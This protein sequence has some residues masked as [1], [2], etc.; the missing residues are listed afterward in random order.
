MRPFSL[1]VFL[2]LVSGAAFGQTANATITGTVA[3]QTGAVI[4]NAPIEARHVDTG[5]LFLAA[6]TETGNYTIGQLPIGRYEVTVSAPGFKTFNRQGLNLAAAQVLRLDIPMEVG[7]TQESVTITADATLLKTESSAV[8]HNVTVS[9]MQ[10]LPLMPVN[11]GTGATSSS[12]FRDPFAIALLIPGVQYAASTDMI[13]NGTP[14]GTVQYRV[15]GQTAGNLGGLRQFTHQTQPSVDAIEEVAIQTSNYSA[16]FGTVGGAI[17]N[18]TM[19]SGTNQFHGS[20]YDYA[21]NEIMNAAHPYTH[22]KNRERR[23]DYG[24]TIGGPVRIPKVYDGGNKTFFFWGFEQFRNN[25]LVVTTQATVPIEPY[26]RGDFGQVIIGSGLNGVPRNILVGTGASQRDYV[27]PLGRTIQSGTIFDPRST[28]TVIC[29]AAITADCP[30]GNS[31]QVRNP[32]PGNIIPATLFDPVALKVQNLVPLPVGPNHE[33]GQLGNNFQNPW[34]SKRRSEIPSI[35]IDHNLTQRARLS[36]YWSTTGTQ[37]QYAFPNGNAEGLPDPISAA[38][39]TFFKGKTIRLNYDHTLSPTVLLHIGLGWSQMNT[40]DRAPVIDYNPEKELG[41]RGARLNRNFPN[42]T[43]GASTATGG[44]STIG[45][46]GGIQGQGGERRPSAVV[47]LSLV[48]RNH[49]IKFG[50]EWRLERYPTR[51][52]TA[53]AGQYGFTGSGWTTQSSLQGIATSQGS[54]G[55]GYANF[56]LGNVRS[57]TLAV[58]I[59]YGTSKSQ[60]A[61]FVQ[62]NWKIRRNLTLDYGLR[63]DYGT[64]TREDHGRNGNLDLTVPNSSAGGH[65]GGLIFEAQCKCL[66]ADNYPYSIGPRAGLAYTLNNKTVLRGGFGIVYNSTSTFGGS[67]TNDVNGG[68]PGFGEGLFRL[69]DGIPASVNPQWPVFDPAIGH[70]PNS[71]IAAP[72]MLDPNGGRP[73]RQYQWSFSLQREIDRNLVVE[74]AYVANRGVWWSAGGLTSNNDISEALLARYG[75][76]VGNT[77]DRSLLIAQWQNLTTAQRS[78]LASRGVFVPYNGFPLNQNVRQ[79][80][81]PFSQFNTSINPSS[82]PLGKTWY[83]ALQVTVTKRYSHGLT[84]NANYTF[85]KTLDLM[86]SP[87]VFNR[88][89]GKD[90]AGSD[91]PHQF[92]LS[93][94]YIVPR[95]P[96]SVPV[97]GNKIVALLLSDWGIGWY[98]Q[99]QSAGALGRPANGATQPISDWL[100]RGPGGAQLRI[101]EDGKPMNP[102][103]VNWV[104]NKGRQRTDPID[105]NCRCYDPAKTIVL[106]PAAWESVPNATWAAQQ[107]TIRYF[108]GTRIPQENANFSR[109][110]RFGEGGKVTLQVR[111]EFN[112]VFNRLRLPNPTSGGNFNANPTLVNGVYTAG[113][114]TYGNITGGIGVGAQRSG[115]LIGRL[116]F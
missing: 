100:G 12:G 28:Q 71:V 16:E 21:V 113:F 24:F 34:R 97:L 57:I 39:G 48:R 52:F 56:L 51:T 96:E 87:D 69:Q 60:W 27:D 70:T 79:S 83:D 47:N 15:D 7:S 77:A 63:W 43:A 20:V 102:W 72:A 89:L 50:G 2:L 106:N 109:N 85:S 94:D 44:L 93:A 8:V 42:F 33:R 74:A 95:I 73:A 31:V 86:S 58:P 84:L 25:T 46:A 99:Y 11:G 76:Q 36:F 103:S 82:A 64:Y 49:N 66:F 101:G 19:K 98:M 13:V 55:F 61:L 62:D 116:T 45:P 29:D 30:A 3:D 54:T 114:G 9:Q 65:P 111:M 14:D 75:F 67:V 115:L 26:R 32:F 18:V 59:S 6:T 38:R 81:R 108:R 5:A 35:K 1:F 107:T 88:S 22:L 112:N 91:R 10:R 68:T 110:F 4:A 23:H 105:I 80:L 37:A 17:F 78:T 41:L 40:D 104:D 53:A 92:R 90:L